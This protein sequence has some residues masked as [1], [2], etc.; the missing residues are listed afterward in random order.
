MQGDDRRGGEGAREIDDVYRLHFE[1]GNLQAVEILK[2]GKIGD[3]R[4]FTSI[5]SQQVKAGNSRLQKDVGGGAI[6]DMGIYRINAARY[7]S[8]G[9]AGRSVCMELELQRQAAFTEVPE[10]T[11][12]T[13]EISWRSHSFIHN[14]LWSRGPFVV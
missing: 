4:I 5:F 1:R 14:K 7:L 10:M 9:G 6:Y 13:A 8:S 11:S 12:G 2:S 3:P